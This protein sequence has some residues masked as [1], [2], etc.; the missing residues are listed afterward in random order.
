MHTTL[1]LGKIVSNIEL[2]VSSVFLRRKLDEYKHLERACTSH[3][4]LE[5][6]EKHFNLYEMQWDFR[7]KDLCFIVLMQSSTQHNHTLISRVSKYH[8]MVVTI[9]SF[10]WIEISGLKF[11]K[12]ESTALY[13]LHFHQI[14]LSLCFLIKYGH[15]TG[16]EPSCINTNTPAWKLSKFKRQRL[17]LCLYLKTFL[18]LWHT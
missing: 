2:C 5:P 16:Q 6:M 4:V 18:V 10:E 15:N 8:K 17:R 13:W 3:L 11:F 9:C 1:L 12:R 14:K 7:A